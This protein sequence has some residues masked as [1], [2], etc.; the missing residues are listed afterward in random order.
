VYAYDAI[1]QLCIQP[2]NWKDLITDVPFTR[3]DILTLQDPH[4]P[5]LKDISR[6]H[7]TLAGI[8][9]PTKKAEIKATSNSMTGRILK[10]LEESDASVLPSI[11]APEPS[12]MALGKKLS[13]KESYHFSTGAFFCLIS[14]MIS[15]RAAQSFTSTAMERV[16]VNEAARKDPLEV[17]YA[18]IKEKG[19]V[20]VM[21]S[22][23]DL[24]IQL[25]CDQV[26][27]F[28]GGTYKQAPK[29]CHNFLLLAKRGYYNNVIFHRSITN[30][31]IQTGDPT[32]TG[33]GGHSA[34][35]E[36]TFRDEFHPKLTHNARGLL[37]MAN[38]GPHTNSSQ[39]FITF[40]KCK[41]LDNKH[42]IVCLVCVVGTDCSLAKSSGES[43]L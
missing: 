33:K 15:G 26:C 43:R 16:T 11:R 40:D 2:R 18:D 29:T 19:Y 36:Q 1:D 41:H 39:F 9:A 31:M 17:M 12:A 5:L 30:F 8:A 4:R 13:A 21:T 38:R 23:G 35:E 32:G 20:R 37:S 27:R 7:Y 22:L 6:F 34:W 10:Q 42:T 25:H 14:W 24:N 28:Q 3:A